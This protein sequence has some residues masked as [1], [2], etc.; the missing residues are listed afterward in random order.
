MWSGLNNITNMG[1][2]VHFSTSGHGYTLTH[3][4]LESCHLPQSCKKCTAL[5]LENLADPYWISVGCQDK[6][7]SDIVCMN[8]SR[9]LWRSAQFQNETLSVCSYDGIQQNREC[10]KFQWA[11]KE[12]EYLGHCIDDLSFILEIFRAVRCTKWPPIILPG[13][14]SCMFERCFDALCGTNHFMLCTTKSSGGLCLQVQS[15]VS[16]PINLNLFQCTCGTLTTATNVCNGRVDCPDH[17]DERHCKCNSLNMK[18]ISLLSPRHGKLGTQCSLLCKTTVDQC[19]PYQDSDFGYKL[20]PFTIN[21]TYFA[22]QNF[23]TIDHTIL[24]DLVAD[25]KHGEDEYILHKV[26][27][28]TMFFPCSQPNQIACRDGHTKC[29]NIS[30]ICSYTLQDNGLYPLS[31][32]TGE[33]LA[34]CGNF[35][36]SAMFKCPMSYCIPWSHTCDGKWDCPGG[37]DENEAN[38]CHS[39][40]QCANLLKCK[41]TQRCVNLRDTCNR[42]AD[43]PFEDDESLCYVGTIQCPAKCNCLTYAIL[44]MD[45][46]MSSFDLLPQF[47]VIS[48]VGV[49]FLTTIALTD[50]QYFD[51]KYS[52]FLDVC[53]MFH[54]TNKIKVLSLSSNDISVLAQRCF[55]NSQWLRILDLSNNNISFLTSEIFAN[56]V[57]LEMLNL[58]QNPFCMISAHVFHNLTNLE[59]V[60]L[61]KV[62]TPR[63]EGDIFADTNLA[64]LE[65]DNCVLCCLPPEQGKC[66]RV[67]PWYFSCSDLLINSGIKAIFYFMSFTILISNSVCLRLLWKLNNAYFVIVFTISTIDLSSSFP[68]FVLWIGDIVFAGNFGLNFYKWVSNPICILVCGL[69][70]YF[71]I[72]A[73]LMLMFASIARLQIVRR[74]IDTRLKEKGFVSQV[75]VYLVMSCTL[76]SVFVTFCIWFVDMHQNQNLF[77]FSL[78]SPFIDPSGTFLTMK[79]LIWKALIYQIFSIIFIVVTHI[80]LLVALQ[81]STKDIAGNVS[82]QNKILNVVIQL[83]ILTISSI[84]SW[85]PS[86]VTYLV[87]MFLTEY[88]LEVLFWITAVVNPINSIVNPVVI[89]V[90]NSRANWANSRLDVNSFSTVISKFDIVSLIVCWVTKRLCVNCKMMNVL[91]IVIVL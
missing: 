14:I 75:V 87:S 2:L 54:L 44:C 29:Y 62:G 33:H 79:F 41:N 85:I 67:M 74:P 61:L 24:N 31:C 3:K 52:K 11:Q 10:N 91:T 8:R 22:C 46:Q 7:L 37:F 47:L 28:E 12:S 5:L 90:T 32:R 25:C 59:T 34:Q 18:S 77:S 65:A 84:L 81:I 53:D 68:L 83:F 39:T 57:L 82:K 64:L 60:S 88:P 13:N 72:L 43:C 45:M 89:L 73:P 63:V 21:V 66:S 30:A 80:K 6:L 1:E 71:S 40:R 42:K 48:M 56:L 23:E 51:V 16:Q 70:L 49:K 69:F 76:A 78:C 36:C 9:N 17:S 38:M 27:K 50:T 58:S 4:K 55:S 86:C 35:E 19:R 26:L 20:V 15:M